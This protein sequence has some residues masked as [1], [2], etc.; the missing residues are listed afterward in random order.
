MHSKTVTIR[1]IDETPQ[2]KQTKLVI[3]LNEI[4]F[5]DEISEENIYSETG[6]DKNDDC[7]VIKNLNEEPKP[8]VNQDDDGIIDGSDW[9]DDSKGPNE[10]GEP[11]KYYG[12]VIDDE[13]VIVLH[14][15]ASSDD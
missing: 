8:V 14:L 15:Y 4:R 13:P 3:G 10:F 11:R 6:T 2:R 12:Y 1:V 7:Y 5:A 9:V